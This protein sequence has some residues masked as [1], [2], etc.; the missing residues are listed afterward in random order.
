[1]DK[2]IVLS[3]MLNQFLFGIIYGMIYG[4]VMLNTTIFAVRLICGLFLMLGIFFGVIMFFVN[5]ESEVNN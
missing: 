4:M 2:K 3:K 5:L 1:M